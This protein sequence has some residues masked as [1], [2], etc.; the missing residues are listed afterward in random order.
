M[1][2]SNWFQANPTVLRANPPAFPPPPSSQP[3][4]PATVERAILNPPFV[5][6]GVPL[7]SFRCTSDGD[8]SKLAPLEE[9]GHFFS[10]P[11]EKRYKSLKRHLYQDLEDLARRHKVENRLESAIRVAAEE[12]EI[13][14]FHEDFTRRLEWGE[15]SSS[16]LLGHYVFSDAMREEGMLENG[17]AGLMQSSG[18]RVRVDPYAAVAR[19]SE[20]GQGSPFPSVRNYFRHYPGISISLAV[21]DFYR[22]LEQKREEFGNALEFQQMW[23]WSERHW[24]FFEAVSR[25]RDWARS[26]KA[27]ED[28]KSEA[29]DGA[30]NPTSGLPGGVHDLEV[31]CW[32]PELEARKRRHQWAI[33]RRIMTAFETNEEDFPEICAP[34][35]RT[36]D[37]YFSL[38]RYGA[39]EKWYPV[40]RELEGKGRGGIKETMEQINCFESV[41]ASGGGLAEASM[42][43]IKRSQ[44][45][46]SRVTS[47]DESATPERDQGG[48]GEE[49]PTQQDFIRQ[50]TPEP[51]SQSHP[52]TT[53]DS[54][55]SGGGALAKGQG[56]PDPFDDSYGNAEMN[57]R[58]SMSALGDRLAG[59]VSTL[60]PSVS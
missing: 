20:N 47:G 36:L 29:S 49:T 22:R 2:S 27:S 35:G 30:T 25:L 41:L 19:F 10:L 28:G 16:L 14:D 12:R 11:H 3:P 8:L 45:R 44:E 7:R 58:V 17:A 56:P 15:D 55:G 26:K 4:D 57:T 46:E 24:N 5:W 53:K 38:G 60:K 23:E 1:A 33:L 48:S 59:A 52:P 40:D 51:E 32:S 43:V 54:S 13:T 21:T 37:S 42:A 18:G 34:G 6:K 39:K 9:R 50:A 31:I